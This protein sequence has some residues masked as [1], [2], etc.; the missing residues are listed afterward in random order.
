MVVTDLILAQP[1]GLDQGLDILVPEDWLSVLAAHLSSLN[2][3]EVLAVE[4]S[5]PRL[6]KSKVTAYCVVGNYW[7]QTRGNSQLL[8]SVKSCFL[9]SCQKKLRAKFMFTSLNN[10]SKN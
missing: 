1:T 10:S 9:H 3:L 8:V 5:L 4:Q 6:I 7:V 2:N